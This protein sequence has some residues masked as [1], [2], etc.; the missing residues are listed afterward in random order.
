ML[1]MSY[2]DFLRYVG[3]SAV[4]NNP[5]KRFYDFTEGETEDGPEKWIFDVFTG[6][7]FSEIEVS[8]MVEKER[9]CVVNLTQE[10]VY[11]WFINNYARDAK[12]V[13]GAWIRYEN[14]WRISCWFTWKTYNNGSYKEFIEVVKWLK[15]AE[16]YHCGGEETSQKELEEL[17]RNAF[18]FG[19]NEVVKALYEWNEEV[20]EKKEESKYYRF[21]Y[22]NFPKT[23]AGYYLKRCV[24]FY[25]WLKNKGI[26][27]VIN[28]Y[29]WQYARN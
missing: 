10:E 22:F 27:D 7:R 2:E 4:E 11:L 26:F 25:G 6:F 28:K 18:I 8:D 16:Y 29:N 12:D 24:L 1:V 21:S 3:F 5:E 14:D 13:P 17:V 23:E 19:F 9:K 20:K 15:Y